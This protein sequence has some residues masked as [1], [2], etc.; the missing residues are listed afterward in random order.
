MIMMITMIMGCR[1]GWRVMC[2][3]THRR[4]RDGRKKWR[5]GRKGRL[6]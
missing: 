3:S 2:L 6:E 4:S 1:R 5:E